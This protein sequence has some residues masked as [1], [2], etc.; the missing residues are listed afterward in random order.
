MLNALMTSQPHPEPRAA[1]RMRIVKQSTRELDRAPARTIK[2]LVASRD[3]ML[4]DVVRH[5]LASDEFTII[6]AKSRA[7]AVMRALVTRPDVIVLTVLPNNESY[8]V[9]IE[10]IPSLAAIPTL[11]L[12]PRRL[13]YERL[14]GFHEES[15]LQLA[16]PITPA[17]VRDALVA[18]LAE[19]DLIAE[20]DRSAARY[21]LAQRELLSECERSQ[22]VETPAQDP[23][24]KDGFRGALGLI[25]LSSLL[26][27]LEVERVE[28]HLHIRSAKR[29][30]RGEVSIRAGAPIKA[31]LVARPELDSL[32][33]LGELLTWEE[34][35]FRFQAARVDG[36]DQINRPVIG[37]MMEA[38]RLTDERR[39]AA[40]ADAANT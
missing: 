29:G 11:Y 22:R 33:A 31:R 37:A 10:D 25:S 24:H 13:M 32:T 7:E 30:R 23:G 35:S 2:V 16:A 6:S 17:R 8:T 12:T 34:G 4:R 19:R 9:Q 26:S 40:S 20:R 27:M 15:D 38:A 5:G 1:A 36:E 21:R 18:L 39:A 14:E 3:G 28:G